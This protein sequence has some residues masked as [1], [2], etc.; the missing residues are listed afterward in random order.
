MRWLR[1]NEESGNHIS[2]NYIIIFK[3]KI[4]K[5]KKKAEGIEFIPLILVS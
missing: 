2:F 1:R 5:I 4:K 3:C